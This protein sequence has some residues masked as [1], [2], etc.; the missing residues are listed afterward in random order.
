MSSS[1]IRIPT[2]S[3]LAQCLNLLRKEET[4]SAEDWARIAQW[5]RFDPRLAEEW[6][7]T[8]GRHWK[9]LSPVLIREANLKQHTPAVMGLLLEQFRIFLCPKRDRALFKLWSAVVLHRTPKAQGEGF[10]IG[11]LPFAGN[12]VREGAE[13]PAVY[14]KKWGFLGQE[15]FVNKF[16]LKQKQLQR[17]TLGPDER[18]LI[19][20][21]LF[22]KNRKITVKDYLEA[23]HGLISRRV[24]QMDLETMPGVQAEG[25]TRN[26]SFS[27][28]PPLISPKSKL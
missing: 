26:C 15:V 22:E 3:E 6:L 13:K 10:L 24:A 18:K 7:T 11:V 21:E 9:I 19:L 12:A 23:C 8:L 4:P 27:K 1:R 20:I 28:L 16:A 14:Y 2:P 17:T 5:T 25:R